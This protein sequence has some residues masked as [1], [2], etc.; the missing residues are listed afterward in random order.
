MTTLLARRNTRMRTYERL[1]LSNTLSA[2]F[3][4]LDELELS[5]YMS[6]VSKTREC[7]WPKLEAALIEWQIRYDRH[8]DSSNTTGD[9]LRYKATEF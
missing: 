1:T 3:S 2:K 4:H 9:L 7:R 6:L 8:P 5:T